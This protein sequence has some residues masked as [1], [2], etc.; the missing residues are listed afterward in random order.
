MKTSPSSNGPIAITIEAEFP[1]PSN[2]VGAFR[3]RAGKEKP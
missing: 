2:P 1:R 3:K